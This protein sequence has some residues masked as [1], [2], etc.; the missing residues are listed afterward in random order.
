MQVGVLFLV[1]FILVRV[2]NHR[3]EVAV[4]VAVAVALAVA[5]TS[6]KVQ[7][8]AANRQVSRRTAAHELTCLETG[9]S[10]TG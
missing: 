2:W 5:Q 4:E 3:A 8:L 1:F 10:Q 6:V 9:D 7:K